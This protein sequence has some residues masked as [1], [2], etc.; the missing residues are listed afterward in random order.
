MA[1]TIVFEPYAVTVLCNIVQTIV[2]NHNVVLTGHAEW[3][4]V[5][6]F[7]RDENGEV[8]GG[9]PGDIWAAW[10]HVRTLSVAAP[11]RGRGSVPNSM[12]S[13]AAAPMRFSTPSVSKHDPFTKNSAI[14]SLGFLRIIRSDISTTL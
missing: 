11:V 12:R 13:N 8:L 6:F 9:L 1:S 7:L 5:A 3:Y 4:P 14:A 2:D 10:L